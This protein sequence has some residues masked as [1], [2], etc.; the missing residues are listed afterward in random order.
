M[1]PSLDPFPSPLVETEWLGP[2]LGA[3]GLAVFDGSWRLPGGGRARDDYDAR[4]IEGTHFFDIDAIADHA[5]DL[6]HMLPAPEAFAAAMGELGVSED[7]AVVVYDDKGLFSAARVWWTLRAM[8]HTRVSVLNGGLRAWDAEGRPVVSTRTQLRAATY[9]PSLYSGSVVGSRDVAFAAAEGSKLI[10]DAR[11]RGRFEGLDPEPRPSLRRGRIPA[12]RSL[13]FAELIGPDGRMLERAALAAR[14]AEAGLD[15]RPVI[16]TCGSGITA[17]VLV[18]ALAV[19][20]REDVALYDG[21][22]AEWGRIEN[23]PARFPVIAG[24]A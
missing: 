2:R 11:P 9:R 17:A 8:G 18:L 16:T 10:L 12:S 20:G 1:T 5:T 24:D 3:P 23:N 19:L 6:P 14:F 13:P 7:A 4:H 21:A 22:F 15:D